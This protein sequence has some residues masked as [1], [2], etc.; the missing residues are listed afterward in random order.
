MIIPFKRTFSETEQNRNLLEELK[1]ELPGIFNWAME[2]LKR[3]QLNEYRFS[4]SK[5]IE[6]EEKKYKMSQ[7]PVNYF[8]ESMIELDE[9]S[10]I[11]R[12]ELYDLYFHWH[13]QNELLE[14]VKRTRQKFYAEL[15]TLIKGKYLNVHIVRTRGEDFFKGIKFREV[16]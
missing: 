16:G 6:N 14:Q 3:L 4:Y 7:Q 13:S 8:F 5:A 1:E 15:Q 2:G 10:K 12:N 9:N 11:K